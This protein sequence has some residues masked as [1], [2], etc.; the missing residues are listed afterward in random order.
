MKR[1][2]MI[3][4]PQTHRLDFYE[5]PSPWAIGL[6]IVVEL[7]VFLALLFIVPALIYCLAS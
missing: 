4:N 7:V 1:V 5:A 6:R 2:V 3:P